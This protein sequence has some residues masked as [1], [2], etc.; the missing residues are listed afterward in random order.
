[1]VTIFEK[2]KVLAGLRYSYVESRSKVK[3]VTGDNP[4][5]VSS[6][7]DPITARFGLVYQPLKQLSLFSSYANS[8]TLNT[9]IDVNGNILPPS[10][11]DQY[12][13]G[14]KSELFH[15]FFSANVTG[16]KIINSN[17]AQPVLG[18]NNV[19]ELAGEVTSKGIELDVMSKSVNGFSVI[20]GYSYNDT[21]YTK[22]TQYI[23]GSKLRYNPPY[24]GNA[25]LF[26]SLQQP[27]LK[28][29]RVGVT[30]AYIGERMAGRSTRTAVSNDTYKLMPVPAYF[31]FDLHVGYTLDNISIRAK[32]SNLL[33]ELS[34]NV[35]DDNSVNPIAPRMFMATISYKW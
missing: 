25:S 21:R 17:L 13:L 34:Y 6:Y 3:N 9:N 20:A 23:E 26:Y 27:G 24:T 29:F 35:H 33:N 8:F 31:L 12:E 14:A 16:Y 10:F 28:N 2:L 15:G 5:V 19:Y 22:S 18:E 32:V 4:A 11:I 1:M 30:T 7:A